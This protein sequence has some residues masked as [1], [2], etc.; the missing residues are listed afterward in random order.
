MVHLFAIWEHVAQLAFD[1]HAVHFVALSLKYPDLHAVHAFAP[2]HVL[3]FATDDAHVWHE[4]P[5]K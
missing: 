3:Q 4:D 2:V 5:D 1:E